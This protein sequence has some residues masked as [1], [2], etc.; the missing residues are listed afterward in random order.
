MKTFAGDHQHYDTMAAIK[1]VVTL[2]K[3]GV[4][5]QDFARSINGYRATLNK[6]TDKDWTIGKHAFT[7]FVIASMEADKAYNFEV[8]SLRLEV[9][10]PELNKVLDTFTQKARSTPKKVTGYM[11]DTQTRGQDRRGQ[12]DQA[13][14]VHG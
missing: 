4:A 10:F 12:A 3:Q 8:S 5:W 7:A 11:A 1:G 14:Y 2:H 13:C 9:P 6:E